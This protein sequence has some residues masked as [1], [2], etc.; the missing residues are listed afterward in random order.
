MLSQAAEQFPVEIG[1][2]G[3]ESAGLDAA[4]VL[5]GVK[6]DELEGNIH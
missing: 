4:L 6:A 3:D 5:D 1:G 2:N